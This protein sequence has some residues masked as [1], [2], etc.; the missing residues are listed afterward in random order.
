VTEATA[1]NKG[2]IVSIDYSY[3]GVS[4]PGF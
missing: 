2:L 4:N 3:A 1:V